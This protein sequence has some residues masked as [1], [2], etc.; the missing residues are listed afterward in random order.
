MGATVTTPALPWSYRKPR[1]NP[2]LLVP[3]KACYPL[4]R[5]L[6]DRTIGLFQACYRLH[7][8]EGVLA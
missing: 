8:A 6:D 3:M 2:G 1:S 7:I 4:L 5:R